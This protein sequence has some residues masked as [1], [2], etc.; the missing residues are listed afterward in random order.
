MVE[1]V[2]NLIA[3]AVDSN[4]SDIHIEPQEKTFKVRFRVDGVLQD[5]LSQPADRF[6]A[7]A[8]RVKLISGLD[9]AERRLPQDGRMTTRMSGLSMDIRVSSAPCVHGESVVMRLL[10]KEKP[11]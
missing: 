2:N 1:F 5:H 7:V 9:I 3:Q 8:S 4:A 11:C 10:P 6:A